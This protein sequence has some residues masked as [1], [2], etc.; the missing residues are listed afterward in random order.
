MP[1]NSYMPPNAPPS[2]PAHAT[3]PTLSG[4][5]DRSPADLKPRPGNPRIHSELQLTKLMASMRMYGVTKPVLVDESSVIL[6]GHACVQ[7]ALRLNLTA[8]PT[9]VISGLTE[10]MKRGLAIGDNKLGLLSTWDD[11]LLKAEMAL[12]IEDN[13]EIETIGFSTA[14]IDLMFEDPA[15][16]EDQLPELPDAPVSRLGDLWLLGSHR[17]LCGD[18]LKAESYLTVMDGGNAQ[19]AITD[20]PFNLK[21]DGHVSGNGKVKHKEFP[22]ASGEMSKA[23]F[24][25][26]FL[27]PAFAHMDAHAV[28]GSIHFIFMDWRHTVEIQAAAEPLFG[29][30][31][32]M[33][34]WAKDSA[35]MG[36][37][38]RSA[39]ELVF[40][41]K[42]GAAVHINNFALGQ[43]GRY[44]TNVWNYP[45]ANGFRGQD[46]GL[47][48]SHPTPKPVGL[49]ADAIRDCSHRKG[50]ILDPFA[51]SGT[52]L[53]AAER[54][55][56][57][58]RAIELEPKYIDVGIQRWQRLTKKEA[59]LAATGQTWDE[60]RAERLGALALHDDADQEDDDDL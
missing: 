32:Q 29:D 46:H 21:I 55:G 34:I 38:Y 54:T 59:V 4:I 2:P 25:N 39:H 51:G 18:A 20:P 8:I 16:P 26:D 49:I 60:V 10:A 36:S 23:Q 52:V 12:L 45:G 1:K 56:R 35:G 57:Y 19:M 40:V 50:L 31:K 13:F 58:A 44:R 42:K 28:D 7:A 27:R 22:M 11:P 17:L 48:A 5:I 33:C 30:P 24:T 15:D 47:L 9:R 37:F 43:T 3:Q 41:F 53:I 14:E 6:C